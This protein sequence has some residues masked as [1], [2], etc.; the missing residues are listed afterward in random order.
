[1]SERIRNT[2]GAM[3]ETRRAELREEW[4]ERADD[5]D[6]Y[7][8]RRRGVGDTREAEDAEAAA[9]D[10]RIAA[11]ELEAGDEGTANAPECEGHPAGAFDSMGETVYCDGSCQAVRP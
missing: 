3:R 6:K 9:T 10:Y 4:R 7:A 5:L 11:D 2:G 1:M 8:R